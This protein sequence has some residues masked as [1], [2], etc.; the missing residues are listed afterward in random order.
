MR[1]AH[2]GWVLIVQQISQVRDQPPVLLRVWGR[3]DQLPEDE[4]SCL[5]PLG[6][7]AGGEAVSPAIAPLNK[8]DF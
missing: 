2:D 7:S 4:A 3:E 6:L 5:S 8:E 1:A